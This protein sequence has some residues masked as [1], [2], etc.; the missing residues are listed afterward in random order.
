MSWPQAA[1]FN[2][3]TNE[4]ANGANNETMVL[5]WLCIVFT[6]YGG[7][8]AAPFGKKESKTPKPMISSQPRASPYSQPRASP[9]RLCPAS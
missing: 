8:F 2:M 5:K 9:S 3:I 6:R 7:S 1:E 4:Q